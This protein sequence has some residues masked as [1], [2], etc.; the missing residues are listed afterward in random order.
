MDCS[1]ARRRG[2]EMDEVPGST[3]IFELLGY[4]SMVTF[5]ILSELG[6]RKLTLKPEPFRRMLD[7]LVA[8]CLGPRIH[9]HKFSISNLVGR[10]QS[11]E[12]IQF[13]R[14]EGRMS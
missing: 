8:R 9:E 13:G 11:S 1:N 6:E 3:S 7:W 2:S 14:D 10:H 4:E 12:R 5:V